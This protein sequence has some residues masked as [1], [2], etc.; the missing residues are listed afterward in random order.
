MDYNPV[1]YLIEEI[2]TK[3]RLNYSEEQIVPYFDFGVTLEVV[4]RLK[5]KTESSTH[6]DK[7]YPLIWHLINSAVNEIIDNNKT[8]PREVTNLTIIF[9]TETDEN[10]TSRE[11]YD[12]KIIPTLRPM[13]DLFMKYLKESKK[14]KSVDN[15]K[16]DYSENLYWGREGLYGHEGNI[17]DDRLDAIIIDNLNLRV[18]ESCSNNLIIK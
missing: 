13:Y 15:F 12:N 5:E 9:C 3:V 8:N 16:H 10:F 11:R 4:N 6:S 14:L 1:S 7:K 2:V 17:F 18:V